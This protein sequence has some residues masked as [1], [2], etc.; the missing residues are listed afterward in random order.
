MNGMIVGLDDT[1][2]TVVLRDD[3]LAGKVYEWVGLYFLFA[4]KG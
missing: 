2:N 4:K 1:K 3:R